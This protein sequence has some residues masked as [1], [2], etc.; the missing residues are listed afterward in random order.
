MEQRSGQNEKGK[1][2]VYTGKGG[3]PTMV[4]PGLSEPTMEVQLERGQEMSE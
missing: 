4:T 1:N 2:N 3:L